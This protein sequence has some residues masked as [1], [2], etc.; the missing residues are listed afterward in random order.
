MLDWLEFLSFY[1]EDDDKDLLTADKIATGIPF[2]LRLKASTF[3]FESN[4]KYYVSSKSDSNTLYVEQ[5]TEQD[6]FCL[7]EFKEQKNLEQFHTLLEKHKI[8]LTEAQTKI[9]TW[10]TKGLLRCV[11]DV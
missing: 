2:A 6:F 5:I 8:A 10:F 1:T 11:Q 4:S 3:F 9:N 7:Q